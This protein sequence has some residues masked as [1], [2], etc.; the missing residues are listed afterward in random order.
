[1]RCIRWVVTLGLLTPTID[2]HAAELS[3]RSCPPTSLCH[4]VPIPWGNATFEFQ[5]TPSNP[6]VNVRLERS[7][8]QALATVGKITVTSGSKTHEIAGSELG[9]FPPDVFSISVDVSADQDGDALI[10]LHFLYD[11][12]VNLPNMPGGFKVM[13]IAISKMRSHQ[14]HTYELPF[15]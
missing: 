13:N 15:P 14:I 11:F 9:L 3:L 5:A 1:M 12:R 2:G 6:E 7:A 8:D 4:L 10:T